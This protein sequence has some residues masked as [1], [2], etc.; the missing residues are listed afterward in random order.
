V[1]HYIAARENFYK[2]LA[3]LNLKPTR[4]LSKS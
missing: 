2:Q 4:W 3:R 1:V